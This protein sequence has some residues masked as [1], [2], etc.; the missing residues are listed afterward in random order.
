MCTDL[1]TISPWDVHTIVDSVKKT[2]RLLVTH[3]APLTKLGGPMSIC[4]VCHRRG[5]A[6]PEI[7]LAS[8][9]ALVHRHECCLHLEASG[10]GLFERLR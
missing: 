4:D 1:A 3:E 9:G 6:A 7:H 8:C 10:V 2:G 5:A